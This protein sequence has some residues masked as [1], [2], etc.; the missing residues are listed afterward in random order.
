MTPA[1]VV[2]TGATGQLGRQLVT[3]FRDEGWEVVGRW[4]GELDIVD[5]EAGHQ[6]AAEGAAVIINAAAW[7]D[8]DGCALDPDRAIRVNGIAAGRLAEAAAVSGALIVQ[9]ST[10]EVFDGHAERPYREDDEPNPINPYGISKLVGERAVVAAT[11]RH[12]IVRT[13]WIFGPGGRNFPSKIIE[14][15]GRQRAAGQP[16]KVV[17]NEVGN[18]TWAPDLARATHAAVAAFFRGELSAGT[19]HVCGEP[20]VSRFAWAERILET[21]PE[22]SLLPIDAAEYPRPS[23]APLHAV[24][25][26]D[27]ARAIG[28]GPL[29]WITPTRRYAAELAEGSI[30][31]AKA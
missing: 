31:A 3:A 4:H 7:T 10:N 6:L 24:L 16:V 21:M 9:I 28:I 1:K 12:L 8:V 20:P 26:T 17:A 11:P 18:P 25:A 5:E 29:D 15:A 23:R 19:L 14:I 13:A 22:V 30:D 2:V 27:K